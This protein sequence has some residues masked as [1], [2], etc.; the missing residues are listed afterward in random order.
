MIGLLEASKPKSL[1]LYNQT[2]LGLGV[3]WWLKCSE[4]SA[5]LNSETN[6]PSWLFP[7]GDLI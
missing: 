1:I 2:T 6:L 7:A 4:S 3:L 5:N